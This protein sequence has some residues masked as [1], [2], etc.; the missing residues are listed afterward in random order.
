M[1]GCRKKTEQE[2]CCYE[3]YEAVTEDH[4]DVVTNPESPHDAMEDEDDEDEENEC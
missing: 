1:D 4:A 2:G 3:I